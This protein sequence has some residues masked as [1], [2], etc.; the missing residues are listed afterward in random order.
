M[1]KLCWWDRNGRYYSGRRHVPAV[2]SHPTP[3]RMV[4]LHGLPGSHWV[5]TCHLCDTTD[6]LYYHRPCCKSW[7]MDI[8]PSICR[9]WIRTFY[10]RIRLHMVSDRSLCI[11]FDSFIPLWEWDLPKKKSRKKRSAEK[12]EKT[13]NLS[14]GVNTP[15]NVIDEVD[16]SGV[17]VANSRSG[18][19]GATVEDVPD[20]NSS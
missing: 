20:E 3:G 13:M 9:R 17:S 2:A 10:M 16:D 4:P 8:S 15:D 12:S 5:A 11:Q 19:R 18:S 6:I 1:D 7:H 14:S